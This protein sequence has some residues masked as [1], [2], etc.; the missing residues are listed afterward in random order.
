MDSHKPILVT[1]ASGYVGGCLIPA[2]LEKGVPVRTF[3]RNRARIESLSW[4][5]QVQVVE[6]DLL[7]PSDVQ[8]A[9]QNVSTAY[10]LVHNMSSGRGHFVREVASAKNFAA[11]AE[12][13]GVE[14]IIYLGGLADPQSQMGLHLH[15][16]L[17]TGEA[18]RQGR[19]P[20]T[21]FRASL[22]IG[23]GSTSFEMIRYVMEQLP[24]AFGRRWMLNSTQPIAIQN[25]LDY[26]LSALDN[27]ACRGKI[28]EIGG[29]DILTYKETMLAYARI[30]GLKRSVLVLPW[31][32]LGLMARVASILTPVPYPIARPLI[33]GMCTNS[34]V[35]SDLARRDFPDI[36]PIDYPSSLRSALADLEPGRLDFQ[37]QEP[38]SSY[39]ARRRGFFIEAQR[40]N[41][42]AKPAAV[43]Q[44][45]IGLGGENGWYH[46]DWLWKARGLFDRWVGGVGLRGRTSR[47]T[48]K[49]GDSLDFYRV[50][51]V[52]PGRS[53]LL[54]AELKAP[55]LGW[56][57]WRTDPYT[58]NET[59]LTQI[60]YFA[61]KGFGGILYWYLLLPF[62]RLV[63]S[64]LIRAIA[65]RAKAVRPT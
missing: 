35:S 31:V 15:S 61:P 65:R 44:I 5:S 40:I 63:F 1:G 27:P 53:L 10:Y 39:R 45:L 8:T 9:L 56:M 21:E 49:S 29:T 19:V 22:V 52:E 26:L 37:W 14:H 64:G 46:L 50:E 16:R 47:E 23:S 7:S 58:D 36:R 2:L 3:V 13:A 6:G 41:I 30:R 54:K 17:M 42:Q 12:S 33:E 59:L 24:V 60:A 55:G 18:L 32:P 4:Y 62:H 51:I 43:F 38:R 48:L 20:V 25:V 28:Y 57:E 11:E 34:T